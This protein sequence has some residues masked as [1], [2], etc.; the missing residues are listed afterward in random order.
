MIDQT[1]MNHYYAISRGDPI[2]CRWCGKTY[3][4]SHNCAGGVQFYGSREHA[5]KVEATQRFQLGDALDSE[6]FL[7]GLKS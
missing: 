5:N 2:T 7:E 3:V 4:L 1:K 6:D